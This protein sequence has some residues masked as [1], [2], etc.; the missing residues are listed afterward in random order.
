MM[1]KETPC[2]GLQSFKTH[3]NKTQSNW[4][5]KQ[6]EHIVTIRI[7]GVKGFQRMPHI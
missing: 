6:L 4:L 7:Y 5:L 3:K 2:L 1:F